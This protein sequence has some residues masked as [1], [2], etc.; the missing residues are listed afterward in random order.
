MA[1]RTIRNPSTIE[2]W[3]LAHANVGRFLFNWAALEQSLHE[4][5]ETA[6]SLNPL[7]GAI[8]VNNM[9]LRDKI[10]I[11]KTILDAYGHNDAPSLIKTLDAIGTYSAVRNMVAHEFHAA[12]GDSVRFYRMRAKGKFSI[13]ET[14]WSDAD[15]HAAY[16]KIDNFK[17]EIEKKKEAFNPPDLEI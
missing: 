6:F 13:P 11:L 3:V 12:A 1:K 8:L 5:I 17:T 9:Q 7:C 16:D 4:A 2:Q 14:I 10:N 15:F